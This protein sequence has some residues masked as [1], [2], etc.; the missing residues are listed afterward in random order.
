M[1]GIVRIKVERKRVIIMK[2]SDEILEKIRKKNEQIEK[3]KVLT[4]KL[5]KKLLE[6]PDNEKGFLD[7]DLRSSRSK[8]KELEGQLERLQL[9]L[10][11]Q[12]N[13]EQVPKIPAIEALLDK[14]EGKAREYIE[15]CHVEEG[16]RSDSL[17]NQFDSLEKEF[18]KKGLYSNFI[19]KFCYAYRYGR[20]NDKELKEKYQVHKGHELSNDEFERLLDYARKEGSYKEFCASNAEWLDLYGDEEKIERFMRD[21]KDIRRQ[22][23]IERVTKV[24]GEIEDCSNLHF[25][26]DD[27]INGVVKGKKASAK[28]TTID[29]GG[30]HI[31]CYHYRVLVKALKKEKASLEE[32]ILSASGKKA[33]GVSVQGKQ[34]S[35][36]ICK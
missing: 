3:R 21:Q 4:E 19:H 34:K 18:Y 8:L 31:Q 29:A 28:I 12:L 36:E 27:G 23:L 33:K 14:W 26:M 20:L 17:R 32:Q 1:N 9:Q 11:K 16:R 7:W 2:K 10:E 30:H 5:E 35:E 15:E 6:T 25:G 13:K 24:V 22:D